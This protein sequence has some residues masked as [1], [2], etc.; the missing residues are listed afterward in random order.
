[1]MV[2][3]FLGL[4]NLLAIGHATKYCWENSPEAACYYIQ[5]P[6]PKG[7][8][9]CSRNF[10]CQSTVGKT[11]RSQLLY[12]RPTAIPKMIL[13]HRVLKI[14]LMNSFVLCQPTNAAARRLC[15]RLYRPPRRVL[16][17]VCIIFANSFTI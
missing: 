8:K 9:D 7:L 1:M 10:V 2:P 16:S 6:C 14:A 15:R 12:G 4:L 3:L 11:R 5:D 13:A 17:Q